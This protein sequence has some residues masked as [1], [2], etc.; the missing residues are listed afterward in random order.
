MKRSTT[1]VPAVLEGLR[2]V[3]VGDMPKS[4]THNDVLSALGLLNRSTTTLSG[5]KMN[6]T[7]GSLFLSEMFS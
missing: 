7:V 3:K 5:S 4:S 2:H 1:K 6:R